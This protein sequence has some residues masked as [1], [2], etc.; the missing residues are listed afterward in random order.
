MIRVVPHITVYDELQYIPAFVMPIEVASR[1]GLVFRIAHYSFHNR[2]I[3]KLEVDQISHSPEGGRA[4]YDISVSDLSKPLI[5]I[6]LV[7]IV[8]RLL[9]RTGYQ[10]GI[11]HF[12]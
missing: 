7:E 3:F 12:S 1:I 6:V 9:K 8:E 4:G 2:S 5:V 10:V 11:L